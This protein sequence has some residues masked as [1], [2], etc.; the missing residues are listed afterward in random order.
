MHKGKNSRP[1]E[2]WG[3]HRT[4]RE[5]ARSSFVWALPLKQ[6]SGLLAQTSGA[7]AF[8]GATSPWGNL[9]PSSRKTPA[10]SPNPSVIFE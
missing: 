3:I 1:T 4:K 10:L 2:S 7:A 6:A 9:G 5:N 8:L